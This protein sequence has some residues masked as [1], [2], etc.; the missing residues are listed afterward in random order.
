MELIQSV[1]IKPMLDALLI[2]G[3]PV[4]KHLCA[5]GLNRFKTHDPRAFLPASLVYELFSRLDKFE[6][7]SNSLHDLGSAYRL[8]SMG[9]WGEVLLTAPNM[10]SA[11]IGVSQPEMTIISFNRMDLEI[12]GPIATIVD[13]YD[14][15]DC[16]ARRMTEELSCCLLLDSLAEFGG[17]Q[18]R[19]LNLEVT[20]TVIPGHA[21]VDLSQ[22]KVRFCRPELRISF[23]TRWLSNR[24]T[25]N[26]DSVQKKP[27]WKTGTSCAERLTLLFDAMEDGSRPT[28]DFLLKQVNMSRRKLQ[29]QLADEGTSFYELLDTWA[30]TSALVRIADP[31]PIAEISEMLGYSDPAHFT[32]AFKR[33]TGSTPATYRDQLS[34]N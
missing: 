30:M 29:R 31:A 28:L 4:E 5:V 32:R 2:N 12:D 26:I 22:T 20:G 24:L 11:A 6:L 13:R 18:C 10:L 21:N 9:H 14:Y 19:P 27:D 7:S 34:A 1:Y 3:A 8:R 23:P 33:W 15:S 17:P 25:Y 16:R